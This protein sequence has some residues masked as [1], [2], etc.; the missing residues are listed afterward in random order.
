MTGSTEPDSRQLHA[1]ARLLRLSTGVT[2][3]TAITT[4]YILTHGRLYEAIVFNLI[5]ACLA[6]IFAAKD[7]F[8]PAAAIAI[9]AMIGFAFVFYIV[10]YLLLLL[11]LIH[12][13]AASFTLARDVTRLAST[14]FAILA[15]LTTFS[16]SYG[17]IW[18]PDPTLAGPRV[19]S[20][21]F[22]WSG[23]FTF[24]A[25]AYR[26]LFAVYRDV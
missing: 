25:V 7:W 3:I 16:L 22:L 1:L 4:G 19:E 21:Y 23:A 10:V 17:F 24:F 12:A 13:C 18:P 14:L 9:I 2:A 15:L 26:A 8:P 11:C 5:S 20:S 6:P